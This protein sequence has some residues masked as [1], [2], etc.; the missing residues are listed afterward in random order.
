M[1]FVRSTGRELT[2]QEI[3]PVEFRLLA[4]SIPL[5]IVPGEI[6]TADAARERVKGLMAS[7]LYRWE[8]V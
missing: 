3:G 5:P 2:V 4:D 6:E 8:K 7:G 1:K